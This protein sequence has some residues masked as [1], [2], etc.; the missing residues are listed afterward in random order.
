MLDY[1][2]IRLLNPEERAAKAAELQAQPESERQRQ[3][4]DL[5]RYEWECEKGG[6]PLKVL[7]QEIV[8]RVW[9]DVQA[10]RSHHAIICKYHNT[11]WR[12][13]RRW[14]ERAP[15]QAG[16]RVK[17]PD[18][19]RR[20]RNRRHAERP[21]HPPPGYP[22]GRGDPGAG[23]ETLHRRPG[24]G[25][26]QDRHGRPQHRLG[27]SGIRPSRTVRRPSARNANPAGRREFR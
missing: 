15:G 3:L 25:H 10:G 11:P 20:P 9:D 13:S 24:A 2:E 21:R 12:F 14:L 23:T 4:D 22:K 18:G 7:P 17:H 1:R 26:H 16:Q 27:S 19:Q 8:R 5:D 6:R